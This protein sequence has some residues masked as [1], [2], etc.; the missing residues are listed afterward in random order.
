MHNLFVLIFL[1]PSCYPFFFNATKFLQQFRMNWPGTNQG[2]MVKSWA[3][4]PFP[5]TWL[6]ISQKHK[7]YLK[8]AQNGERAKGTGQGH[9][10]SSE[11]GTTAR[12]LQVLALCE[13]SCI[14][15]M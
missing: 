4:M 5:Y 6:E 14:S 7:K 15:V 2:S 11:T 1:F 13:S 12:H 10:L 3:G 9:F 8:R